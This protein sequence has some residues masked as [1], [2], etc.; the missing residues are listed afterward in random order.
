MESSVTGV[1]VLPPEIDADGMKMREKQ[2]EQFLVDRV[3][4]GGGKA[5]KFSSPAN[6]GVPDRIILFPKGR[7]A[8][9]ECKGSRG[10][11]SRLQHKW[12]TDLRDMGFVAEVVDGVEAVEQLMEKMGR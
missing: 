11:L 10:R 9:A 5:P 6:R 8:F 2:V 4:S 1:T 7:V 12:I 3:K